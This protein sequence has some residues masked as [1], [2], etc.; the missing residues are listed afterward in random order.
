VAAISN[1]IYTS[2]NSSIT[3]Q[4]VDYAQHTIPRWTESRPRSI[5]T[6]SVGSIL[7]QLS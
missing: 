4:S 1:V 3:G 6:F 2:L 7:R 5:V